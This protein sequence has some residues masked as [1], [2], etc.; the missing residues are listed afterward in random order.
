MNIVSSFTEPSFQ[1]HHAHWQAVRE[2]QDH[3]RDFSGTHGL[4]ISLRDL[5]DGSRR[6]ATAAMQPVEHGKAMILIRV[7]G[8]WREN[9]AA[10]LLACHFAVEDHPLDLRRFRFCQHPD[11]L[12]LSE[13]NR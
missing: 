9:I 13:G 3:R 6:A 7:V 8:R 10:H 5:R 1:S 4:A 12:L 2:D 11:M